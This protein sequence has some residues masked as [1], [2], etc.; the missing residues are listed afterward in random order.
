MDSNNNY[1]VELTNDCK[2][3]I[4][5][6]YCY[7]RYN[8]EAEDAANKLIEKIEHVIV[9]LAYFPKIYAKINKYENTR[10]IYRRIVIENYIVLFSLD[11]LYKKVYVSHVYYK[12]RDYLDKI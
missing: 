10:R 7:I 1:T 12:G 8:L 5:N 6:I 9:N 3:D 2:K 4:R 11:E